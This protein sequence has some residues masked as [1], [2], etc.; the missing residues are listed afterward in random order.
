MRAQDFSLQDLQCLI[1]QQIGQL[2]Q[3]MAALLS[4]HLE[5]VQRLAEIPGLGVDSAQQI[6]AETSQ[7]RL[8]SR[9]GG[10]CS[11]SAVDFRP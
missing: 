9:G 4:Q 8:Q 11:M 10:L 7:P 3:E 1:E 5:A 6:I 2:H